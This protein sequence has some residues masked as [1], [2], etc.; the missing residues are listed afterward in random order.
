MGRSTSSRI[1]RRRDPEFQWRLADEGNYNAIAC[2][3]GLARKYM[4]KYAGKVPLL[5]KLNGKTTIPSDGHALS[6]ITGSVS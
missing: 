2:H 6:T 5:L 4:T 1:H 3:Y